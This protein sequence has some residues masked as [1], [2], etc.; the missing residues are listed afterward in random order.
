MLGFTDNEVS[1]AA[2]YSNRFAF[3]ERFVAK[4]IGGIN[5][6]KAI[7]GFGHNLLGDNKYIAIDQ[8]CVRRTQRRFMNDCCE[9]VTGVDLADA[10]DAKDLHATHA[11]APKS[12]VRAKDFETPGLL[13]MVSVTMQFNP[14]DSTADLWESSAVSITSVLANSL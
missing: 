4:G 8:R 14:R 7:L 6:N 13:I 12:T 1:A 10:F 5:G 9:I 3:D 11:V 2:K